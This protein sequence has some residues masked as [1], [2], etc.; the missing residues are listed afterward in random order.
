[1]KKHILL[2]SVVS[3]AAVSQAD[4][5]TDLHAANKKLD[6]A[7]KAKD[8][9]TVEATMKA[10][11]TSDFKYIEGGKTQDFK[12]FIGNLNMS[13]VM[14]EKVTSASSRI[15]SLN[16]KGNTATATVEHSIA[17]TMKTGDKKTHTSNWTGTFTEE[18]RKVDGKWKMSKIVPT[19]QKYMMDGKPVKM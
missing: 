5:R 12:T 15:L 10:N 13:I 11:V 4:V 17:G 1:M 18:Y 2:L 14:M 6:A 16:E 3:L 7:I 8:V 9:K 19:A